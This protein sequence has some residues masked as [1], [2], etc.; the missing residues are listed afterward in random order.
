MSDLVL[1]RHALPDT[2]PAVAPERWPLGKASRDAVRRL[3]RRLPADPLV[4]SSNEMRAAQTAD[5]LVSVQGG[6][7]EVDPRLN[8]AR[9]P[10]RWY[11]DYRERAHRYV[12]GQTYGGWE[13]HESV[14]RRVDAGVQPHYTR[15]TVRHWSS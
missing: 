8:E 12:A 5:E 11:A 13:A 6:R 3:A 15:S 4:I 2:D 7:I 14:A 10:N 9:R 1:V